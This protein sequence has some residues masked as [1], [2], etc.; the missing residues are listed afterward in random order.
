MCEVCVCAA[1]S[2]I[3]GRERQTDCDRGEKSDS[4]YA[5][6]EPVAG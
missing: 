1:G 4:S 2:E 6:P 5:F 3:A